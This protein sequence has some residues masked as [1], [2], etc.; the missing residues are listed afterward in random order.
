MNAHTS[1]VELFETT[2]VPAAL[3]KMALP[4]I[5][6]QLITLIYN[7]ADTWFIGRTNNPYMVAASSLVLTIYL[8]TMAAANLFGVGGGTLA[9][10]LLGARRDD[11]ALLNLPLYSP[12]FLIRA[13]AIIAPIYTGNVIP[14]YVRSFENI[15]P[16]PTAITSWNTA[17]AYILTCRMCFFSYSTRIL[18]SSGTTVV[19]RFLLSISFL[20][21]GPPIRLPAIRPN[22]AA[23]VHIV[24]APAMLK[25]SR[26]G[27]KAPAVP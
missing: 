8:I 6:S 13:A 5:M 24:V 16:S 4:T 10:R 23:A 21:I 2:P 20:P 17:S 12:T 27:P 3:A 9:A 18:S 22:V 1:K 19:R 25:S 7:M 14:V 26:T 11:E 15:V